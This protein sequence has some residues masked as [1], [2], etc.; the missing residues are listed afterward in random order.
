MSTFPIS[1]YLYN[2]KNKKNKSAIQSEL[3]SL[4]EERQPQAI[5]S[6]FLKNSLQE[7]M[8]IATVKRGDRYNW[9]LHDPLESS[10]KLLEVI[11]VTN[12]M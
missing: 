9:G 12:D 1:L 4:Y 3:C 11:N 5:N 2:P 8:W 7:F 10:F 6:F